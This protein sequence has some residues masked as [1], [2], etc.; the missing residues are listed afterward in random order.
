MLNTIELKNEKVYNIFYDLKSYIELN[1]YKGYDPYDGLKSKFFKTMPISK[2]PFF[3]I[4]WT[5]FIKKFPLN[6]RNFVG[7]KKGHNP[8]ALALILSSYCNVYNTSIQSTDN[9]REL[10]RSIRHLADILIMMRNND[11]SGACWGYEFD[12]NSR[13]FYL[14]KFTP[15]I[16]CTSFVLDAL[17]KAFGILDDDHIHDCIVSSK[18]FILNDLNRIKKQNGSFVFSYSPIDK[19]AVYNASLLGVKSLALIYSLTDDASLKEIA[20]NAVVAACNNQLLSGAFRHSDQV[21]DKWRDNFHTGFKI[22]CLSIYQKT[23]NDDN[24]KENINIGLKYWLS[25]FFL[26]NGIPKYYDNKIYPIDLHTVG[27]MIPT[28]YHSDSIEE[29]HA[30]I[31]K[32]LNWSFDNMLKKNGS[33]YFQMHRYWKNKIEYL[34]WPNA[35]MLYGI[36]YYIKYLSDDKKN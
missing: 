35:W 3:R 17:V 14:P 29:N 20:H 2:I 4:A 11:Y 6:I 24:F 27:Q 33:F 26:P 25:N 32:T 31:L 13:A 1:D 18:E 30:S 15:T 10:R 12:W 22:E 19:R 23:F 16:V 8:K 28:L 7:I 21:G 34:R 36:S 5:Q 9:L